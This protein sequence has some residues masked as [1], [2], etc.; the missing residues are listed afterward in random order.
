MPKIA[1]S[2]ILALRDSRSAGNETRLVTYFWVLYYTA[3]GHWEL[4]GI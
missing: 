3:S 1:V 4:K 2:L